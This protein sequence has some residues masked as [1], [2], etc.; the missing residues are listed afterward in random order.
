MHSKWKIKA[1]IKFA[2]LI[3][4]FELAKWAIIFWMNY[5]LQFGLLLLIAWPLLS[6][7]PRSAL[8]RCYRVW[9][10]LCVFQLKSYHERASSLDCRSGIY[11]KAEFSGITVR[12][13]LYKVSSLTSHYYDVTTRTKFARF[14]QKIAG[15]PSP[16][17]KLSLFLV[18]LYLEGY[19]NY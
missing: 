16:E 7:T 11:G 14:F 15:F 6:K 19:S 4:W 2:L 18:K 13:Y 9:R 8:A 3:D 1:L 12:M 5:K 17:I 10:L